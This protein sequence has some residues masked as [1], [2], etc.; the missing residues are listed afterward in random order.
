MAGIGVSIWAVLKYVPLPY[1]D[2]VYMAVGLGVGIPFLFTLWIKF[3]QEVYGTPRKAILIT[4]ILLGAL[5]PSLWAIITKSGLD[6]S[7]KVS[8]S[9][10]LGVGLPCLVPIIA[11]FTYDRRLFGARKGQQ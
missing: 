11:Y 7:V 2:R 8:L 6:L 4:I 5:A 10:G 3:L 9:V 1:G